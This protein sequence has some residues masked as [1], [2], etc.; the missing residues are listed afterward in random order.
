MSTATE[1]IRSRER[2]LI[3][4]ILN[5]DLV[6]L[7]TILAAGFVYTAS[8]I[9]RRSRQE[10]LD[11]IAI[12]RLGVFEIVDMEIE[13]FGDVALV[14]ARIHQDAEIHGKHRLGPFLVTDVWV[15]RDGSW[16]IVS[17]TSVAGE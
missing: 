3:S 12:Y 7:E 5:A 16:Q 14:H 8:E 1:E 13:D 9:G 4:A 10:W 15:R 6:K 11:G 2:E 17:R